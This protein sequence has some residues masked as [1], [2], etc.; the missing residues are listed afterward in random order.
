VYQKT[1]QINFEINDNMYLL[2]PLKKAEVC[3]KFRSAWKGPYKIVSKL[4]S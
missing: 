4:S 2:C 3:Q 1:K